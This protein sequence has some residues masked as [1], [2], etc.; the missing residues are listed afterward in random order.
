M[1]L[2][3]S[4]L[5]GAGAGA[6][7]G[8]GAGAA[9]GGEAAAAA[10]SAG[11]AGV[12]TGAAAGLGTVAGAAGLALAPLLIYQMFAQ[13]RHGPL[14]FMVGGEPTPYQRFGGNLAG[15]LRTTNQAINELSQ[16]LQGSQTQGDVYRAIQNYKDAVR[17]GYETT[18]DVVG[19]FGVGTAA[20]DIPVPPGAGGSKHEWGISADFGAP[21]AQLQ[22]FATQ[23]LQRL[24]AG[25]AQSF[26]SAGERRAALQISRG[27]PVG[28]NDNPGTVQ[29]AKAAGWVYSPY[30]GAYVPPDQVVTGQTQNA[31]GS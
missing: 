14:G 23:A 11:L 8:A 25:G 15:T 20:G 10:G 13:N 12:G 24:P 22:Q 1:S 2:L 3:T 19:G 30:Q 6:G 17:W 21:I 27:T 5:S 9:L 31:G 28:I 16:Q 26:Q 4:G 29:A 7:L 18:G